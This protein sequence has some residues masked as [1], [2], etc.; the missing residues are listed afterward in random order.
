MK[1]TEVP[2][3]LIWPETHY[4][5]IEKTGPFQNAA[6]ECWQAMHKLIPS[7]SACNTVE[8][9]FSLYN[10]EVHIYRAGVS[11]AAAPKNLPEGIRYEKVPGGKYHLFTLTGP[12]SQLPDATGR[13][14]E[15][16][17]EKKIPIRDGFNIEHYVTDPRVTPEA[18]LITEIMFPAA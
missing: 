15:I 2:D 12:F 13:A 1:L 3:L 4:V 16:I 14:F 9:Y 7:I 18:E 6:P 5:F 17:A 10:C 11:L 8:K